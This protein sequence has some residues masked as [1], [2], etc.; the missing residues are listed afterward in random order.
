MIENSTYVRRARTRN[1]DENGSAL[2]NNLIMLYLF[3]C[4]VQNLHRQ[5]GFLYYERAF[6]RTNVISFVL[7]KVSFVDGRDCCRGGFEKKR[8][9]CMGMTRDGDR[10]RYTRAEIVKRK[11][12]AHYFIQNKLQK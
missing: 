4:L 9:I 5:I 10:D 11:C 6:Y 8:Y 12:I 7:R 1:M 3:S 2:N